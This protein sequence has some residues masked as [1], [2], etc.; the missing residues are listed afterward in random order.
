ME[1][2]PKLWLFFYRVVLKGVNSI[3]NTKNLMKKL[4]QPNSLF[5]QGKSPPRVPLFGAKMWGKPFFTE[6][7]WKILHWVFRSNFFWESLC[8][9]RTQEKILRKKVNVKFF[10]V[11]PYR[12]PTHFLDFFFC[13]CLGF[14]GQEFMIF[15]FLKKK[16]LK[17]TEFLIMS[18]IFSPFP[19]FW[20]FKKIV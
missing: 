6:P 7:P 19:L 20:I 16:W 13:W 3:G 15:S 5:L 17:L 8:I 12:S 2:S 14:F 10:T 11:D 4:K 9:Y 1:I 18:P